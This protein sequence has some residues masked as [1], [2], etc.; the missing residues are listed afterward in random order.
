MEESTV[1]EDDALLVSSDSD[2]TDMLT[3]QRTQ[4]S[5]A[6]LLLV[7]SQLSSTLSMTVVYRSTYSEPGEAYSRRYGSCRS[8]SERET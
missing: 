7:H 3:Y 6:R 4:Y 2:A 5:V 1:E 8:G